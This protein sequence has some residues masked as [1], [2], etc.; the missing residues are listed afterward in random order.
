MNGRLR[1]RLNDGDERKVDHILLATG[2]RVNISRYP[3]LAT[4]LAESVKKTDNYPVLDACHECSVPN[5]HFLGAPGVWSF[6]P[7]MGHVA[8]TEFSSR[9][10]ARRVSGKC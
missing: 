7:M 3:F 9:A 4:E 5:L 10:L 1:V 6:G 2:Y 8:G